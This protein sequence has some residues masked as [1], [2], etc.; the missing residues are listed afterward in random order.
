MTITN[1]TISGNSASLGGGNGAGGGIYNGG[2]STVNLTNST[3]SSN[4]AS[5]AAGGI[6]NFG[7]TVTISNST[8]SGNLASLGGGGILTTVGT[9]TITNSTISG[10]T[11]GNGGG[12]YRIDGTT[13]ARNTIIAKNAAITGPDFSGTLTSQ[14][15]NLIGNTSG[16]TFAAGSDTTGNQLSVDPHVGYDAQG[17]RRSYSRHSPCFPA[18]RPS[19]KATPAARTRINAASNDRQVFPTVSATA[20]TS[21]P[22]KCRPINCPAA[23]TSVVTNN[24]DDGSSGSLRTIITNACPGG[25]VTFAANVRGVI[26]LTSGELVINKAL[27]ISGPGANLLSVQRSAAV[28]TPAFRIFNITANFNVNISG[29][30]ISNGNAP[31][32]F[33][34]GIF[35]DGATLT[36]TN[37]TVSGN[38]AASG[39]GIYNTGVGFLTIANSTI[40]GNSG[41]G[42]G[43]FNDNGLVTINNSTISGNSAQFFGGGIYNFSSNM[44]IT[45]ST[46][47]GNTAGSSGGGGISNDSNGTV[48][49]RS[50]I[51]ALNTSASG[52]DVKGVFESQSFNVIGNNSGATITPQATDQIGVTA[53]QL[54]LG[55]LQDNGG[56]T[57][58][59]ALLSGSTAIDKGYSFLSTTDQRGFPR[60]VGIANVW[61]R[62]RRRHR[63]I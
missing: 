50:T 3:I 14:G 15:Y 35:N 23:A 25:T 30:T 9:V 6:Y 10:N 39:G 52:P 19:T 13:N 11:A 43:I 24:L 37:C 40:S 46:I 34:G 18:A 20:R 60:P 48:D 5:G 61:W 21:A 57:F 62:R 27:T 12:I 41:N 31:G 36:I 53:A 8:I 45:N 26:N 4:S 56:P 22:T 38:A 17:Q 7:G 47:A 29:L 51:I 58:T 59:R 54:N 33:G 42:G 16:M 63:R 32:N 1:S 28:G 49:V 55:P 2:S 44:T